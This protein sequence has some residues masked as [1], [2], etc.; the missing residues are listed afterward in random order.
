MCFFTFLCGV[1]GQVWYLIVSIPYL[2]LLPYFHYVKIFQVNK[3]LK[4]FDM[5]YFR[6]VGIAKTNSFN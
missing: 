3:G 6:S 2:C 5:I 4:E 1:L